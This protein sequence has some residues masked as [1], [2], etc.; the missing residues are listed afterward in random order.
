MLDP[1][2]AAAK[3]N[4]LNFKRTLTLAFVDS[5]DLISVQAEISEISSVEM[6]IFL[7]NTQQAKQST[8]T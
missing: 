7:T 8:W 3:V 4:K 5:L 2:S 6:C 1:Q